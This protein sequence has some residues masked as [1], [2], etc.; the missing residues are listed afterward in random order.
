[1]KYL[2]P[3]TFNTYIHPMNHRKACITVLS[4]FIYFLPQNIYSDNIEKAN[5]YYEKYDYKYAIGIYEKIMSKKPSREVAQ[6]LANCYRFI[7]NTE[8]SEKA[9]SRVL[10][11]PGFDPVNYKYYADALKQNGKFEEAKKNYLLYAQA[12]P[13]EAAEGIKMANSADVARMWSAS[14]DMNVRIENEF[15]LNTEYAEFSPVKFNGGLVFVS[16]RWFSQ[17]SARGKLKKKTIYGWTGNPYL[18]LYTADMTTRGAPKIL[19]LPQQINNEFHNSSAVFTANYDT[20][21]F[22]RTEISTKANNKPGVGRK[23]IYFSHRTA[24]SWSAPRRILFSGPGSFSVQHPALSP[25]GDILYFASDM[26][27]GS[28]G[29]DIY[30]SRKGPDG[31]WGTP[32]NCG[33]NINTSGDEVFPYVREDGTF[34]FSSSGHV[35]MG[36]LDVLRSTGSFDRFTPAENL[37]APVNSSKDDFGILFTDNN[38]GYISSNRKGGRGLDDIYHFTIAP[39]A[40]PVAAEAAGSKEKAGMFFAIEGEVMESVSGLPMKDVLIHLLNQDT[41]EKKTTQSNEQGKFNFDLEPGMNYIVRGDRDKYFSKEEGYVS[42]KNLSESTI[43]TVK[44]DLEKAQD[45]YLVR[46][47]NIYYNFNKWNIRRDAKPELNK[48]ITFIR[49]MPDVKIELRSHTDSRGPASYNLWLSQ[50][51]AHSA[52]D[53]LRINGGVKS[54]NLT[55]VGLGENELLNRCH[56]NVRCSEKEHQLNRRTEFK[57]INASQKPPLASIP[58]AGI[59]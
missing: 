46:L 56:D 18:K 21:F 36:G 11:F 57:I 45:A 15:A 24:N 58:M 28:G 6:K 31:M 33:L 47:N 22:T 2:C 14:P 16:D 12:I 59:R 37:R 40:R 53:Y 50:K 42:T 3:D 41:G 52:A 55:A 27:G 35:G 49:T 9:Y 43:F 25:Q 23:S 7:N 34:Y 10:G 13:L 51:R 30:A 54:T 29:M 38:S 5:R 44:F 17:G 4:V 32:V 48:V 20:I 19:L 26:P 39:A 8:A 1:M